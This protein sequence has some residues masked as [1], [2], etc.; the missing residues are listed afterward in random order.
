MFFSWRKLSGIRYCRLCLL[1]RVLEIAQQQSCRLWLGFPGPWFASIVPDSARD[2]LWNWVG[3][4]SF[5]GV[6]RSRLGRHQASQCS[7]PRICVHLSTTG[8]VLMKLEQVLF[9]FV[10]EFD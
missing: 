7:L 9:V 2:F 1:L 3:L 8:A 10:L 4:L 6:S 5:G